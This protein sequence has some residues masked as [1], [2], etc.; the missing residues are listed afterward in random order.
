MSVNTTPTIGPGIGSRHPWQTAAAALVLAMLAACGAKQDAAAT[1]SATSG[2]AATAGAEKSGLVLEKEQI[3][4]LG[5]TT[6]PAK[7]G[8]FVAE[9]SGYGQV[10]GHESVALMTAEIATANAAARQSR[11]A[12]TRITDLAGTPGAFPAESLESA[13]RQAA[14]DAAAL[15]LA[16]QKLTAAL[17]Q[18]G[19]W[20]GASGSGVLNALA[21]GQIKLVRATFASGALSAGTPKRLRLA[22]FAAGNSAHNWKS[23]A[24]WDA[25]ADTGM[26][27][28]SFFA[29]LSGSDA[30]E[31]ERLQ[32]WASGEGAAQSGVVVPSAAVVLSNDAYWCF[33]EKPAGTFVRTAVDTSRPVDGGYFVTE[34]VAVGDAIVTTAAGLLL[35]RES[36]PSTEAE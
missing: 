6:Q 28:R 32:V 34:G 31:G 13:E 16:Q 29:L 14:T 3:D 7:A 9:I 8:S 23:G 25:P 35:A 17:G 24:V 10:L 2:D 12:L 20:N 5:L 22:H 18:R 36:N 27:G 33:V 15:N 11:A 30:S 19:P 26:P 1:E 4:K 21:T